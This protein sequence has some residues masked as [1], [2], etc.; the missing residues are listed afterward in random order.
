MFYINYIFLYI[1][2]IDVNYYNIFYFCIIK[3]KYKNVKKNPYNNDLIIKLAL[4]GLGVQ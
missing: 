4:F 3:R 1:I 2:Y